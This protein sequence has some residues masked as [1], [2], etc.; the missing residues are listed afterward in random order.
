MST[1]TSQAFVSFFSCLPRRALISFEGTEASIVSSPDLN[2]FRSRGM[3][4]A[5]LNCR[6]GTTPAYCQLLIHA[7]AT[8]L[9][10]GALW[11]VTVA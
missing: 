3:L 11:K 1:T 4:F 7:S 9:P 5:L 8:C 10:S 2:S 6:V